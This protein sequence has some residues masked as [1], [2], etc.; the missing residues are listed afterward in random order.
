MAID[1]VNPL[2]AG[3][4]LVRS[5]VR[6]QNYH[7]GTDG[8]IIQSNGNAEFNNLTVRG[9]FNGSNF[10]INSSGIF[11]YNGTPAAGNL[12]G[13]WTSASGTDSF[14][15]NY[16]AGFSIYQGASTQYLIDTSGNLTVGSSTGAHFT[17]SNGATPTMKA[18]DSLGRQCLQLDSNTG[19]MTVLDN[20]DLNFIQLN[21]TTAQT[22][23]GIAVGTLPTAGVM[24]TA[25]QVANAGGIYNLNGSSL[26]MHS[27]IGAPV[28]YTTYAGTFLTAGQSGKVT[29]SG[30]NPVVQIYAL[31]I[32]NASDVDLHV[33]GSV[34]KTDQSGN[35]YTWQ[36]P[37]YNANW[38]GWNAFNGLTGYAP[39]QYRLDAENNLIIT[40]TFK[41]G[42]TVPGGAVFNLPAGYRPNGGGAIPI[43]CQRNNAGALSA[44]HA[45]ISTGG[46]VD[47]FAAAGVGIA[48]GNEYIIN[49]IVPLN[50]IP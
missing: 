31:P 39:L 30:L 36:T 8:W 29:G 42:T 5:D 49:G 15:N 18:F 12:I 17:F 7:T 34:V 23:G 11:M 32:A 26:G 22:P 33:S 1:F 16:N 46:N 10:T 27:P 20:T 24:P 21:T 48:A 28:T 4:V 41:A 2:T 38:A 35:A 37:T 50:N 9:V 44:G 43:F 6:S 3:T 45:Y 14:G 40:G 13:S 19:L 25:T 47:L